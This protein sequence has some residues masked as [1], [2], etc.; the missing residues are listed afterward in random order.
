MLTI[1]MLREDPERVIA[2]LAVKNFDAREIVSKVLELDANRR[3]IQTESDALLARQKQLSSKIGGLM[4]EGKR[5][6]AEEVKREVTALRPSLL[7]FS[8]RRTPTTK[9]WM[10]LSSFSRTSLA[11][12]WFPAKAPRITRL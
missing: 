6:E 7:S 3:A 1:K 5:E 10:T 8:P 11:T 2:K 9:S 12:L 4:K